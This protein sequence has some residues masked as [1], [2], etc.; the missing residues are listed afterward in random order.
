MG[1]SL[2][3]YILRRLAWMAIVLLII[4]T[5]SFFL[6]RFAPGGPFDKERTLPEAIEKN[7]RAKYHLD[8]PLAVQYII[9]MGGLIRGDLGPSFKY[10]NRSV[11]TIIAQSFPISLT[12]GI[13]AL[14]L[15]FIV[16][17]S[18][19]TFA[20]VNKHSA[21]DYATMSITLLGIS[22]PNF[23]LG[24]ILLLL[25]CFE[26]PLFPA[27]GWGRP[28]Q[29][30]LPILTLA[31]PFTAYIARLMR[32]SMLDV[33]SQP[34]IRT[35]RA[36]GLSEFQVVSRHALKNAITPIVSFMG[37]AAAAVLTGSIVIEKIFAIP[38]L[39]THFV[40]A[41]LNRDYTLVMGTVLLY[42]FLLVL[43]NLAV[44]IVYSF[45]DPRV[46]L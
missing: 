16:G 20:A 11:N 4:A 46:R 37:P 3:V 44:D 18:A 7:L 21:L 23:F 15:A 34:Y 8:R 25:F 22:L 33:L 17:V 12:L 32:A 41:A 45:I 19:G 40:N 30:V 42:S 1:A 2:T 35:A 28:G 14:S 43:F 6:M 24:L 9:Y 10:R 13:Y 27:A 31:A 26:L 29:M 36:K 38:G 39:G 5:A